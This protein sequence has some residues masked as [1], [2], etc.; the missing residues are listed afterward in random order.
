M[1]R[2]PEAFLRKSHMTKACKNGHIFAVDIAA[3]QAYDRAHSL[4]ECASCRNHSAQAREK[5]LELNA[6]AASAWTLPAPTRP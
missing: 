6:Y 4:C 1:M 5:P 3:T 2:P